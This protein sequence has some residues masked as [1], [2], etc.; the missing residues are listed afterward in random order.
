M[1]N[2]SLCFFVNPP[3]I[4]GRLSLAVGVVS[5]GAN[6]S[7]NL[8]NA[9]S[10]SSSKLSRLAGMSNFLSVGSSYSLSNSILI[11]VGVVSSIVAVTVGVVVVFG[12][13]V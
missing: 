2:R 5:I 8:G 11:G 7:D 10:H 6:K 1:T 12:V 4:V 13:N 3:F 9:S